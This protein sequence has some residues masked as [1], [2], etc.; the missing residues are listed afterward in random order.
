MDRKVRFL[1][2]AFFLTLFPSLFGTPITFLFQSTATTVDISADFTSFHPVAM[3]QAAGGLWKYSLELEPG[4]YRYFFLQDGKATLDPKNVSLVRFQDMLVNVRVVAQ[5]GIPQKGDGQAASFTFA[6]ERPFVN[7]VQPG[8]I[9]LSAAFSEN[10]A[11]GIQLLVNGT[12]LQE[13]VFSQDAKTWTRFHVRSEAPKLYYAFLLEDGQPVYF[14]ESPEELFHFDFRNPPVGYLLPPEWSRGITYY[15]VFPERF[16]NGDSSNDPYPRMEPGATMTQD[17]L[18][19]SFF[20]GDLDGIR[21]SLSYFKELGIGALYLNPI[22]QAPSTHKYDTSDYEKIDEGFGNMA[23]FEALVHSLQTNNIRLVLDGVFN[24][25]GTSF[26]AM[27]EN[28]DLQQKSRFL[29]W[30]HILRFPITFS[31]ESYRCWFNY[32]SLPQFHHQNPQLKAYLL[33]VAFFW[34]AKGIDGWRLDAA[35]QP[36]LSFWTE[37][38]YPQLKNVVPDALLVGEY[39]RDASVY[40]QDPAFDAVMNYR[41]RDAILAYCQGGRA[42]S[43]VNEIQDMRNTY[44][45]QVLDSLWNMLGSHDTPR[46]RTALGENDQA[47]KAAV[48]LQM[49]MPGCPVIYYGDELGMTGATDPFCRQPFGS[50]PTHEPT[51]RLYQ[52][53]LALRK[54]SEALKTGEYSVLQTSRQALVFERKTAEERIVVAV[55]TGSRQ[56]PLGVTLG[57]EMRDIFSGETMDTLSSL[58]G[59]TTLVLEPVGGEEQ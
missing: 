44:P 16:V 26:F 38:F 13:E 5:R 7:P 31:A 35:D 20:G 59:N 33:H 8:E 1:H 30:F 42:S 36:P 49:T 19:N 54:R 4:T 10:D 53:L 57:E 9:F 23:A 43:F 55:N 50:Q 48:S 56:V 27:R 3:A 52:A 15:Q 40:F 37:T 12:V 58:P 22:F 11:D 17:I 46:I 2:L 25:S 14:P 24:H 47:L 21:K 41:F 29:D 51:S 39:W 6:H 18:A 45:P 34:L 28:F 32:P